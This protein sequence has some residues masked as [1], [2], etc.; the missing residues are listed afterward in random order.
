MRTLALLLA[1]AALPAFAQETKDTKPAAPKEERRPLNLKLDNPGSWAT[2]APS[3]A[4]KDPKSDLP[5][6][7]EDAR[8]MPAEIP[9]STTKSPFPE[10]S[11]P[12]R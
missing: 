7:G 9:R 12:G 3:T 6:L 2:V 4:P 1:C 8:T 11:N 10:D 5:S